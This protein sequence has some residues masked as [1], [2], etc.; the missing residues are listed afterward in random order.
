[1]IMEK[2]LYFNYIQKYFPKLV[3]GITETLNDKNQ[4]ALP[5]LHKQL[6]GTDYSV[7][8]RWES[9]TGTYSRVAADV[10]AMD[11]AL[12]LK[13]RDTLS[14][15]SGDLPK[16]GMELYLNEKQMSDIDALI[17]Q[18]ADIN[19]IVSKIFADTPRVITGVLERLEH[20][21]LYGL[22]HGEAV[23]D[24][25]N[26]GTGIRLNYNYLPANQMG[27]IDEWD[28]P[29]TAKPLD[30]IGNIVNRANE[31]GYNVRFMYA[32]QATI[33]NFLACDQVRQQYAFSIGYVGALTSVPIPDLAQANNVLNSKFGITLVKVNRSI[34]TEVDGVQTPVNPWNV[35]TAVFTVDQRVGS[36]VWTRL[37][38]QNHL[39]DGVSYQT[40]NEFILVSKYRVNRPSLRE[41]TTSQARV[42]PVIANVDRVFTLDTT[43]VQA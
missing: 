21:F 1:M 28:Q 43:T 31:L 7:D 6:L 3:L 36:V 30:D 10:V 35:G 18:G 32:D 9:L 39:V 14:R 8:G 42:V 25:E 40:A 26:V 12:P 19:M 11:S 34:I 20:M 15:A 24:T 2:S 41:Y 29:T 16:M 13:K 33:T 4:A 27:V 22:S 5:Y 17:A 38:E 23:V 37:A